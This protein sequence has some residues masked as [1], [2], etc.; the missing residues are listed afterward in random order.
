MTNNNNTNKNRCHIP[1]LRVEDEKESK[2]R[3]EQQQREKKHKE[4]ELDREPAHRVAGRTR[5]RD[6][7][8]KALVEGMGITKTG[9]NKIG[10]KSK[11]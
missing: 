6:M 11:E 3:E 9:S 2:I 10:Q 8:R 5:E 1:C 7:E 4:E